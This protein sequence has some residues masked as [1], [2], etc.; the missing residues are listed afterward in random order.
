MLWKISAKDFWKIINSLTF[1]IGTRAGSAGKPV[2][3]PLRSSSLEELHMQE[4]SYWKV[5]RAI[6]QRA[7]QLREEQV[8]LETGASSADGAEA[9]EVVALNEDGDAAK[10]DQSLLEDSLDRMMDQEPSG[11]SPT[12]E[13]VKALAA[14]VGP[15]PA[16]TVEP[17]PAPS[18]E[19][20]PA[21][22]EPLPAPSVE[23]AP[24]EILSALA[25]VDLSKPI[26][27]KGEDKVD[28]PASDP[29]GL[30]W[31]WKGLIHWQ[32]LHCLR[33]LNQVLRHL[34]WRLR[35]SHPVRTLKVWSLMEMLKWSV[36][37]MKMNLMKNRL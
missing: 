24:L 34:T 32:V 8:Q 11:P 28:E 37:V 6:E 17:L 4:S 20:L 2:A 7:E 1:L 23:P 35:N 10:A 12:A 30:L 19:P 9:T 14:P 36:M 3:A 25:A 29:A 21:Q 31:K 22:S 16:S 13:E 33:H 18:V 27:L 5:Q 26:Q 15:L